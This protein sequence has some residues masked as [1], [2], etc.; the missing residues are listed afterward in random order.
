MIPDFVLKLV[1][2]FVPALAFGLQRQRGHKPIGFGTFVFVS[3]GG[4]GVGALAMLLAP[5]NPLP[6]LGAIV[7][8]IGFLGAGALIK[9]G[10]KVYGF[11]SAALIWIFAIFGMTMGVGRFSLGMAIYVFVW[12][13]ILCDSYLEKRGIGAY[14]K[15]LTIRV[16]GLMAQGEIEKQLAVIKRY[17]LVS[18]EVSKTGNKTAVTYLIEARA[19]D[20]EGVMDRLVQNEWFD[21]YTVE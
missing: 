3:T 18:L 16:N 2:T 5:S 4:C 21:S 12:L 11:T 13:V 6:L 8:G 20:L 15:K 14:R 1:F 9:T 10:E 17:K 7:T 19:G